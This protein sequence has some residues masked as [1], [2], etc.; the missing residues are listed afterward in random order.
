MQQ[1][2]FWTGL[3]TL[4]I[5]G[6]LVLVMI[7]ARRLMVRLKDESPVTAD[8]GLNPPRLSLIVPACNEAL[9]VQAAVQSMLAQDYSNLEI[10]LVNDR[11]TDQTGQIMDQIADQHSH[12]KVVHIDQLPGGWLGKNHAMWLGTKHATGDWL[13][14]S[15]ADI[16][17][18]PTTFRRAIALAERRGLDHLTLTPDM[19]VRGFWLESWVA[20][21]VL[22]IMIYKVPHRANRTDSKVG[23]GIGAFNL[24]RRTAY[25]AIGTHQAI[26]L[27]PDDDLRLGQRIK[28]MGKRQ[29][30]MTGTGLM[31]V[32]WY[33]S[34]WEAIRGLEKNTFAGL[35]YSLLRVALAVISITLLMI[36]PFI[37]LLLAN[38]TALWLH[39]GVAAIHLVLFA[40]VHAQIGTR[41]FPGFLTF[42]IAALLFLFTVVR[43]T[44]V[45]VAQGGITWRGTFYPLDQLR[46]QSGLPEP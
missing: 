33:S 25:E 6:Y 3:V 17:F 24:V 44:W 12:V 14:F 7:G 43:A 41:I 15:D 8:P 34:L 11:S 36:W 31:R 30:I 38:G 5:M 29:M 32:R 19:T 22:C 42:P 26:S 35:E 10:V 18:D 39:L 13:L 16:H 20:F 2:L 23:V 4:C 21:F 28:L 46:S 9:S 40:G 27:R 37:A 1:F 45:T